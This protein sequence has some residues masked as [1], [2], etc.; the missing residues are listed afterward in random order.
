MP[1]TNRIISA[2]DLGEV[3]PFPLGALGDG[4]DTPLKRRMVLQ[5]EG[6]KSPPAAPQV[7]PAERREELARQRQQQLRASFDAGYREGMQAGRSAAI[8]QH[9][10]EARALGATL[11]QRVEMLAASLEAELEAFHVAGADR[12]LDLGIEIA[13]Q[14]VRRAI[15]QDRETIVAVVQESLSQLHDESAP[16]A[17][18]LNPV[19]VPFVETHLAALLARRRVELRPDPSIAIGGCRLVSA[20]AE[21]DA[22]IETRWRRALAALGRSADDEPLSA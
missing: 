16:A 10:Q 15:A 13:R 3:R 1:T 6:P 7:D 21:V 14:T 17:L 18:S 11:R 2:E 12:L 5:R 20:Q 22:T 4:P 9:E 19:D 8:Q